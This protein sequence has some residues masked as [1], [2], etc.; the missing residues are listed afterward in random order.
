MSLIQS[1]GC[2]QHFEDFLDD[3]GEPFILP[4][5]DPDKCYRF[6]QRSWLW[7]LI[8]GATGKVWNAISGFFNSGGK[9]SGGSGGVLS[10][11]AGSG[12]N[13]GGFSGG[14]SSFGFGGNGGNYGT[15]TGSG[16]GGGYNINL[17]TIFSEFELKKIQKAA[18]WINNQ[19][20][21]N[22]N[23]LDLYL[24]MDLDCIWALSDFL[25]NPGVP[26]IGDEA[27]LPE[28]VMAQLISMILDMFPSNRGRCCGNRIF[29]IQP[30]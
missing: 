7:E 14:T 3:P 26:T 27:G 24:L 15:G 29:I 22:L 9:G 6:K 30:L 20:G 1:C 10:S 17:A 4:R 5:Q 19:Y 23:T 2:S 21:F 16:P 11:G 18:G 8:G 25:Q 13:F 28:C 12:G